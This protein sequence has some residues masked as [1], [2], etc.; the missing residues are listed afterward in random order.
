[1]RRLSFF[2]VILSL[3]IIYIHLTSCSIM[4]NSRKKLVTRRSMLWSRLLLPLS[5]IYTP[6]SDEIKLCYITHYKSGAGT[7][8]IPWE[9]NNDL[10]ATTTNMNASYE[11]KNS[12]IDNSGYE[13]L[14]WRFELFQTVLKF[15]SCRS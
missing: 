7:W 8:T 9:T 10:M 15:L 11:N 5:L 3:Y 4:H 14:I 13:R 6:K 1:M 12:Q 2:L